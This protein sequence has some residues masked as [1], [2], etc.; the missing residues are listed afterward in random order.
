[1]REEQ[2]KNGNIR[3]AT[4][5]GKPTLKMLLPELKDM[6]TN[7]TFFF[8]TLAQVAVIWYFGAI[9]SFYPKILLLKFGVTS[10]QIGYILGAALAPSIGSK[11]R[12]RVTVINTHNFHISVKLYDN[13]F[14]F[15]FT[16]RLAR[17]LKISMRS[18]RMV[19]FFSSR[20]NYIANMFN[21]K[22]Q[23]DLYVYTSSVNCKVFRKASL[24]FNYIVS[25][26]YTVYSACDAFKIDL[27]IKQDGEW[28]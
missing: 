16:K 11:C 27:I 21:I 5:T 4:K 23:L 3:K 24:G 13:I 8:N 19:K 22:I 6:L 2:I 10:E 25:L 20:D 28:L 9:I 14:L 17:I 26:S 15:L 12:H 18:K 7:W 1:M